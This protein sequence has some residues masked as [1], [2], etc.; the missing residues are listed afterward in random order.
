MGTLL[1]TRTSKPLKQYYIDA[2]MKEWKLSVDD[3]NIQKL[4]SIQT[5]TN[6]ETLRKRVRFIATCKGL[7]KIDVHALV[8]KVW[9]TVLQNEK[10]HEKYVKVFLRDMMVVD[11]VVHYQILQAA[12]GAWLEALRKWHP[13]QELIE[14]LIEKN[15]PNNRLLIKPVL[16][17]S[18]FQ[19]IVPLYQCL[20]NLGLNSDDNP[21]S[22]VMVKGK[23]MDFFHGIKHLANKDWSS[24]HVI[25]SMLWFDIAHQLNDRVSMKKI[26][27]LWLKNVG[28]S[29]RGGRY[30]LTPFNTFLSISSIDVQSSED[31]Y[32]KYR[33]HDLLGDLSPNIQALFTDEESRASLY[34][35]LNHL[36]MTSLDVMHYYQEHLSCSE[37]S[38]HF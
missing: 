27:H 17:I 32:L 14:V 3:A 13:Y 21:L 23:Y 29:H 16:Y 20:S 30:A 8:P 25:D 4:N 12:N 35:L 1:N 33:F 2:F 18:N 37:E 36:E 24:I 22:D 5:I 34:T 38:L 26:T 19:D 6:I 31:W 7:E 11:E 9:L 10:P 28:V 15:K